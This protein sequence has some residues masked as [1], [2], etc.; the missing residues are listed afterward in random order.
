[1]NLDKIFVLL[2]NGFLC[3][4]LLDPSSQNTTVLELMQDPKDIKDSSGKSLTQDITSIAFC[5]TVPPK[6]DC[7]IFSDR[8][9]PFIAYPH[10]DKQLVDNFIVMGLSKGSIIFLSVEEFD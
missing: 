5:N 2:A 1:M 7:E 10:P 6:L 3:I 9:D 8:P 4:Y